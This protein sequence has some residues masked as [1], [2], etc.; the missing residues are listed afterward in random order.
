MS[1]RQAVAISHYNVISDVL[2]VAAFNHAG[3]KSRAASNV[4]SRFRP[5]GVCVGGKHCLGIIGNNL[6][7]FLT[8]PY[9]STVRE[10]AHWLT[11]GEHLL[12]IPLSAD[13]YGL[14]IGVG[15]SGSSLNI[16]SL[17]VPVTFHVLCRRRCPGVVSCGVTNRTVQC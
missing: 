12:I 1:V 7:I 13:I 17:R 9:H 3:P 6:M 16:D 11:R 4:A 8:K 15:S 10:K 5:G 2:Q 14:V